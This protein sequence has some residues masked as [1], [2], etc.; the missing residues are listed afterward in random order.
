LE[1]LVPN[2]TPVL[3]LPDGRFSGLP[4]SWSDSAK[5][6][7]AAIREDHPNLDAATD[8]QL[9]EACSLIALSDE[10]QA[11]IDLDGL[12]VPG[13]RGQLAQHP[14]AASVIRSRAQAIA[15]LRALGLARGQSSA[16]AAGAALVAK[17]HHGVRPGR[18]AAQ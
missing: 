6:T 2:L 8:A 5:E 17:R 10:M 11:R 7:F 9:Y 14:L 12:V 16:S 1:A 13:S 15:A 18:R 3:P 4:A